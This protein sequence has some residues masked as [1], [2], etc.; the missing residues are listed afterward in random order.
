M[1]Q[2][3]QEKTQ[4]FGPCDYCGSISR[5]VAGLITR[6]GG[7]YAGYQ[8]HWTPGQ[9]E[10]HGAGF[11]IILGYWGEGTVA[12][13][14]YAVAVRYRADSEA[15]GFMVVDAD[16]TRIASHPLVGRALRRE[17]VVDTPL[18]REVFDIVDFIWLHDDRITEITHA[19]RA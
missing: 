15:T 2:L 18:A 12:A 14:R 10:K 17:E 6:D 8:V 5:L 1:F 16:Q 7:A 9:I 11:F 19:G 13:D 3:E 4:E